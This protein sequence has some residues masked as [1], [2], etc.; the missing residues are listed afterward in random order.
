MVLDTVGCP[1]TL[2]G[3]DE[4]N[5]GGGGGGKGGVAGKRGGGGKG[6]AEIG[7][8]EGRTAPQFVQKRKPSEFISPQVLQS[9]PGSVGVKE[10]VGDVG[11][12]DGGKDSLTA[13]GG[14]E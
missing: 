14:A 2:G 11:G 1:E 5:G 8:V 9:L 12:P 10:I 3:V 7:F 4:E 13:G 6:G